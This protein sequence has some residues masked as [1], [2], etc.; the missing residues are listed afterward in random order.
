MRRGKVRLNLDFIMQE[1]KNIVLRE[2][3]LD[4]QHEIL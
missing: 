1:L 3:S 4:G 2:R